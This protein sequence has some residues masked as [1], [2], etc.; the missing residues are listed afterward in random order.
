MHAIGA[1]RDFQNNFGL[2]WCVVLGSTETPELDKLISFAEELEA[3]IPGDDEEPDQFL[4][5]F[6][7]EPQNLYDEG[8][9]EDKLFERASG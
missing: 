4:V 2:V 5:Q 8:E 6:G 7:D 1:S 9:I 3:F